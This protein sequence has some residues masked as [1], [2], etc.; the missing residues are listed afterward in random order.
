MKLQ[1]SQLT[2]CCITNAACN[3]KLAAMTLRKLLGGYHLTS[4]PVM[5]TRVAS[6]LGEEEAY[7]FGLQ[8]Q[9][10]VHHWGTVKPEVQS[11]SHHDSQEQRKTNASTIVCLA[12]YPQLTFLFLILSKAPCLGSDGT[13]NGLC[14]STSINNQD[15]PTDMPSSLEPTLEYPSLRLFSGD[16]RLCQVNS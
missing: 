4:A 15:K 9:V 1:P 7:L 11:R 14:I 3:L 13:H 2:K 12:A 6:N 8:F 10:T 5:S 16:S